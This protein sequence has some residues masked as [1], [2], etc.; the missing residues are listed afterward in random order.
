MNRC[1]VKCSNVGCC[2]LQARVLRNPCQGIHQHD[3]APVVKYPQSP[4]THIYALL[5]MI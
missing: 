1:N 5:Q 4:N 2:S 3:D